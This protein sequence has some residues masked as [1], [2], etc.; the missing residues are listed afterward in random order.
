MKNLSFETMIFWYFARTSGIMD[1]RKKETIVVS[2]NSSFVVKSNNKGLAASNI[3][4]E[5]FLTGLS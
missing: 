3:S 5:I 1:E 2:R 4:V